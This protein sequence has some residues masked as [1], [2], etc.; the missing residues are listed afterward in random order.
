MIEFYL[1]GALLS[2]LQYNKY[3]DYSFDF[4][5]I[6]VKSQSGC[7][8]SNDATTQQPPK[9]KFNRN[10]FVLISLYNL[11]YTLFLI[12]MVVYLVYIF[13]FVMKFLNKSDSYGDFVLLKNIASFNPKYDAFLTVPNKFVNTVFKTMVMSLV[14]NVILVQMVIFFRGQIE[15]SDRKKIKQDLK[16]IMLVSILI[17][18]FTFMFV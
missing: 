14:L 13:E 18:G 10:E 16:L 9:F 3:V 12:S 15:E 4:G 8:S 11:L 6:D 2:F 7:N 1:I 17:F 5:N